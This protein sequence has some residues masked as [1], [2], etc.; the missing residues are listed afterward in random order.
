ML[1]NGLDGFA[2]CL[3]GVLEGVGKLVRLALFAGELCLRCLF[4]LWV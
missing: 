3:A 4:D 1:V 2:G